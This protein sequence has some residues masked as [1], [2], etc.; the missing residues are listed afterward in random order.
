M[1]EQFAEIKVTGFD[2]LRD[3]LFRLERELR[4]RIA[5]E[6]VQAGV[7]VLLPAIE[8][9]APVRSGVLAG[10]IDQSEVIS[11]AGGLKTVA[12]VGPNISDGYRGLWIERGT[13][14]RYTHTK[15]FRGKITASPF[16]VP[17]A[18]SAA[19]AVQDAIGARLASLIEQ[20]AASI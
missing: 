15:R 13:E 4:T 16:V 11:Y 18:E 9:A 3:K 20:V 6:A 19:S 2:E 12:V 8:A 17:A 1:A 7:N 10:S 14:D 5:R